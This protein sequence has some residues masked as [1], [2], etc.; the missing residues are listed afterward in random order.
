MVVLQRVFVLVLLQWAVFADRAAEVVL[1]LEQ[2]E[3]PYQHLDHSCLHWT[4]V[5]SHLPLAL[6]LLPGRP[7]LIQTRLVHHEH[8]YQG[9]QHLGPRYHQHQ[10]RPHLDQSPCHPD[11]VTLAQRAVPACV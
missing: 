4:Y 1:A 11:L 9:H 3:C 2:S 7:L 6:V 8:P 5:S 10:A